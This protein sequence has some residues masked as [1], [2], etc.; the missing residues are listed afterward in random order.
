MSWIG[1]V[2]RSSIGVSPPNITSDYKRA[3]GLLAYLY[4]GYESSPG[5]RQYTT[6]T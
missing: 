6:S 4:N 3:I 2:V 1:A 5:T